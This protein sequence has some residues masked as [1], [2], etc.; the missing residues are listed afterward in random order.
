MSQP[1]VS[2]LIPTY[3]GERFLRPALRSAVEQ[4]YRDIEIVIADDASTDRTAEIV[5]EAAAVDPRVRVI[6]H[7]TNVGGFENPRR[8]LDAARGEYVKFL[9]HDDVLAND[10]VKELVRGMESSPEVS[11]AFSRRT[12]IDE[13]GQRIAGHEFAQLLDRPGTIDGRELGNAM[14][15]GCTNVVGELTTVLFRRGDV[16]IS[17]LWQVD[18][19]RLDVL[20]DLALWLRLLAR[21]PAFYTPR[22]LSRFR[23]HGTQNSRDPRLIARGV[24][25]WPRLIDW[26]RRNGLLADAAQH[27]RALARALQIGAARAA[28][29][30]AG[31]ESGPAL[32]TV[33]LA[34][35]GLVEAGGAFPADG[36][37]AL[38]VRAHAPEFLAR[39]RQ[40]L[41]VWSRRL[42]V[43]LAAPAVDEVEITATVRA[44]R[45]VLAAGAAERVALTVAPAL[46]EQAAPLVK[47]AVA[48]GPDLD[49]EILPSDAPSSVLPGPWLAVAPAG[50]SWDDGKA[51]A[52]WRFA[53]PRQ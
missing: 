48:E 38:D 34:V 31:P 32:E 18:G 36:Q 35:T 45:D 28:E 47:S 42:P 4:T 44:L 43:A 14:L 26:G 16:E 2:I 20:G 17:D 5:A 50:R 53:V 52:V 46:V 9:L 15:E 10:C 40:E 22:T 23:V 8:L 49:V 6:R 27:R 37:Q 39:L 29:L 1:L 21:G 24:R 19:R 11:L 7:E 41:D 30:S 51:S 33:F 25:D 13:K 3:N 12:L